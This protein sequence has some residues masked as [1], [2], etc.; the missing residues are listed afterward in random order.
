MLYYQVASE[1][2]QRRFSV[3][4][5][6]QYLQVQETPLFTVVCLPDERGKFPTV[7]MR[8]PYVDYAENQPEEFSVEKTVSMQKAFIENGYAVYTPIL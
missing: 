2:T 4:A 5:Y 3:K 7:I 1:T 8:S 6:Y